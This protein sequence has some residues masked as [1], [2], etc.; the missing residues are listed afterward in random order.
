MQ[1]RI[2][3]PRVSGGIFKGAHGFL[4]NALLL[5]HRCLCVASLDADAPCARIARTASASRAACCSRTVACT[6]CAV[7]YACA[8]YHAR[9]TAWRKPYG[10]CRPR[11][12]GGRDDIRNVWRHSCRRFRGLAWWRGWRWAHK[13]ARRHMI[14]SGWHGGG[15]ASCI[16][17]SITHGTCIARI[18]FM[19]ALSIAAWRAARRC[20][21]GK[22]RSGNQAAT[23][24]RG[25]GCYIINIAITTRESAKTRSAASRRRWRGACRRQLAARMAGD[26]R[27]NAQTRLGARIA[28][29]QNGAWLGIARALAD[30]ASANAA[31]QHRGA[32]RNGAAN[33]VRRGING[34]I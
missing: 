20:V 2:F 3:T 9:Q 22:Q 34:E 32:A 16:L 7:V 29:R 17:S 18:G 10:A 12:T 21:H 24:E 25:I 27:L 33:G 30:A 4:V 28:L 19:R 6:S 23:G 13:R 31:Q 14:G 15:A 1:H 11:H 26:K 8:D 5:P